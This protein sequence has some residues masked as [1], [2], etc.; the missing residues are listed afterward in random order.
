V[1]IYTRDERVV[2]DFSRLNV[3]RIL[4]NQPSTEGAIGGIFNA[5]RPSLTLACGPGAGNLNTDN[6]TTDHLINIH[7]VARFHDNRAWTSVPK[8]VWLDPAVGWPQIVRIYRDRKEP[9]EG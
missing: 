1:G 6:I 8:Q 2:A 7:R 4:V 5:L 9:S 3:A